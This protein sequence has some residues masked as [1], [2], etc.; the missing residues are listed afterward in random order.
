MIDYMWDKGSRDDRPGGQ[1]SDQGEFLPLNF[2]LKPGLGYTKAGV[3]NFSEL[4]VIWIFITSS[5]DHLIKKPWA[6]SE[7]HLCARVLPL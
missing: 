4:R 5:I 1:M 2:R 7:K 3:I 6:A